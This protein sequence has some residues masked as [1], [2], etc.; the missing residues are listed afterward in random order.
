MS[1]VT[2]FTISIVEADLGL[3][4]TIQC[5]FLQLFQLREERTEAETVTQRGRTIPDNAQH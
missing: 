2:I 1:R 5:H 4:R 3:G